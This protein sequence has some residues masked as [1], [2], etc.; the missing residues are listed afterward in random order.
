LDFEA[1]RLRPQNQ[2]SNGI[3]AEMDGHCK[4]VYYE[5]IIKLIDFYD[6]AAAGSA[7][8]PVAV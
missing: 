3:A 6:G 7:V 8:K 5:L 2:K 1:R 4:S